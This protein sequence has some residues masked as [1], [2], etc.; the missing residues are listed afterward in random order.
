MEWIHIFNGTV[1]SPDILTYVIRIPFWL[2]GK[3]IGE[4]RVE[5]SVYCK[6]VIDGCYGG[7]GCMSGKKNKKKKKE[8]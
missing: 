7:D 2:I 3:T 1:L 5:L 6:V 8:K 4:R